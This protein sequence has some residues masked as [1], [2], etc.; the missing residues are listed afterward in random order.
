VNCDFITDVVTM[1]ITHT[2]NAIWALIMLTK[3]EIKS[4]FT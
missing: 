3:S 4:Q 1:I 2:P